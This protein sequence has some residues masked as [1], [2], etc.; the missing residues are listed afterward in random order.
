MVCGFQLTEKV[1]NRFLMTV[2]ANCCRFLDS[3]NRKMGLR[4]EMDSSRAEKMAG[5]LV[6]C[7]DSGRR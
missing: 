1:M 7:S 2:K 6:G 5:R 3:A 4:A